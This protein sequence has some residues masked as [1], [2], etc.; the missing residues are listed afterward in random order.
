MMLAHVVE[1]LTAAGARVRAVDGRVRVEA[2]P[3]VLTPE[4]KATISAEKDALLALL[5]EPR[6]RPVPCIRCGRF[7][8]VEPTVCFWCRQGGR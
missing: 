7:H 1:T 6:T 4:M 5:A 3:G 2:P 8:Y